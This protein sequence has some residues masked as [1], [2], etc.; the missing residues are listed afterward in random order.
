MGAGRGQ[1]LM[2][3]MTLAYSEIVRSVENCAMEL[4]AWM[5]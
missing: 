2:S 4:A 1:G 5:L 3:Q